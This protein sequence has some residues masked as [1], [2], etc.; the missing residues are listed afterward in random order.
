VSVIELRDVRVR[1][2]SRLAV[3]G[4]SARAAAGEWIGLIGP[5]GAG[6]TTLLRVLAGL[7]DHDGEVLLDGEPAARM[8]RRQR[9]QRIALVPQRPLIPPAMTVSE[10]VLMGRT[11]YIRYLDVESRGDVRIVTG[12]LQRLDIDGFA[13]RTLGSLSGGEQQRVILA[14]ALAQQ[15]PTLLLDEGTSALDIGGQQEV[16]ELVASLR[17]SHELT[18]ISAMHDLTL[19]GQFCDR[20]LLMADGRIVADGEPRA[21]LTEET[22]RAYYGANVRVIEAPDGSVS[23]L[24]IR[25]EAV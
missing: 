6:K 1:Y 24:P 7:L 8:R 14:R 13:D 4:V 22:I 20:L 12:V 2:G 15:A 25:S 9:A 5:N 17:A 21:V 3:D 11:P 18:V 16:L 19:A 23:V 10:Y